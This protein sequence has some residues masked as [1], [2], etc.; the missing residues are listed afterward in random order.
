MGKI[1]LIAISGKKQSGKSLVGKII[2]YLLTEKNPDVQEFIEKYL[3]PS[4]NIENSNWELKQLAGKVKEM[5]CLI[6]GCTMENL[7]DEEFKSSYMSEEWN[8]FKPTG[9]IDGSEIIN[10]VIFSTKERA[11]KWS[12]QHTNYAH[13][14]YKERITY[15]QGLQLIGTDLFRDKFHPNTWINALF[16]DYKSKVYQFSTFPDGG[17][18][19]TK[20]YPNWLI[21]D[22]RFLNE[23]QA[24]KDRDGILIRVN[25]D[26]RKAAL[27]LMENTPCDGSEFLDKNLDR[28]SEHKSE[29]ELDAFTGWD[30]IIDNNGSIED[31]IEKVRKILIKIKLI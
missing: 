9:R 11:L 2:Q 6:T 24:V 8:R 13:G 12:K 18:M 19:M 31:L 5:L 23:V 7:E 3:R 21:T 15:R 30:Y 20:D 16:A 4:I 1:N 10:D 27:S 14:Y 22:L 29:T 26:W 17:P 25:R 28:V